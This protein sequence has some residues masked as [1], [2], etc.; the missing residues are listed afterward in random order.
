[1]GLRSEEDWIGRSKLCCSR[2]YSE[3]VMLSS[4]EEACDVAG[5]PGMLSSSRSR[6]ASDE[7]RTVTGLSGMLSPSRSRT[8]SRGFR[9]LTPTNASS[10]RIFRTADKDR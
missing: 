4:D 2:R 8:G 6:T 10:A 9:S 5:L 1:M 7:V 3:A